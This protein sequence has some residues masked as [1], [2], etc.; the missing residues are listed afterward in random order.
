[1]KIR[2]FAPLMAAAATA[3]IFTA[4]A[5]LADST[6]TSCNYL[7]GALDTQ[8]SS[9]GNTQINDAPPVVQY[10]PQYPYWEG[11]FIGGFGGFHGGHR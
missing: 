10:G 4:P 11:G 1:M 6:T 3:A 7:N 5:A 8:C 2:Y 9:P